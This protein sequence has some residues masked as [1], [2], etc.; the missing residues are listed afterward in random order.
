MPAVDHHRR[1][2]LDDE[3]EL[4]RSLLPPHVRPP[5]NSHGLFVL[6]AV[7][8]R[9]K[10]EHTSLS[11]VHDAWAAWRQQEDPSHACLVPFPDLD[12]PTREL[13]VPYLYAIRAASRMRARRAANPRLPGG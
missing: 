12:E 6:Y 4:I 3:A 10:G 5:E 8:M 11:D 13:D 9:A 7:L 1:S 2:Y